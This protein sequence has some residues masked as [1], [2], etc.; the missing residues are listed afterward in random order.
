[1]ETKI[2]YTSTDVGK[3]FRFEDRNKS[4][5]NLFNAEERGDIPK[6]ERISRGKVNVRNWK[7]E[8]IPAIGRRF[9]FLAQP[10]EQQVICVYTAKGGVLKTAIAHSI[11]RTLALHGIK[12]LII[13][14]DIQRSIT[15]IVLPKDDVES[16]DQ[17]NDGPLGLYHLLFEKASLDEVILKTDLP[18]LDIIPETAELNMLEKKLR[19]E[20]RKEYVLKD[21]LLPRLKDYQVVIFDNSPNW[22][23]LI[24]NALTASNNVVSP[25][26]CDL[27]TYQALKTNLE[28]VSDFQKSMKLE[29][30]NYIFVPT[31]YEKTKLSQ[32]IYAAYVHQYPNEILPG[33]IRRA[34]G[35]PEALVLR[36]TIFEHAPRSPLADDYYE[37]L[38][39]L[40]DKVLASEAHH[41]A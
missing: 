22:N 7:A 9:G 39:A 31:L 40:W 29:W 28:T 19:F 4:P 17:A 16:L 35:G 5:V 3:I 33:F 21:K 32:Q 23:Q 18:T 14:L 37:I 27:G 20:N 6:A 8:D 41:G 12:T 24:E 38:K 1:M 13:G 10:T 30:D 34:V 36:K 26:G 15:E 25:I 11:A 2:V